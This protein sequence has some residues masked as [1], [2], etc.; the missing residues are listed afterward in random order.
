MYAVSDGQGAHQEEIMRMLI[1]KGA[2]LNIQD[3]VC[4]LNGLTR[5]LSYS[6]ESKLIKMLFIEWFNCT[7]GGCDD[8][9][10]RDCST[11]RRERSEFGYQG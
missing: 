4:L 7:N 11:A 8:R 6:Y 1:E 5:S 3:E 9:A 10:G 2:C